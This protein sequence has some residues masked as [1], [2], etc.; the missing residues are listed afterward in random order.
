MEMQDVFL[1]QQVVHHIQVVQ[2]E[3]VQVLKEILETLFVGGHL[4]Q[5]VC[6]RHVIKTQLQL[7]IVIVIHSL[8]VV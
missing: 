4:D 1:K 6:Q 5:I 7:K 2:L 8:Q 3:L